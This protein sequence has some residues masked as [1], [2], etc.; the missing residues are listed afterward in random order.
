M[1]TIRGDLAA[2][3]GL[4][5]VAA[6]GSIV[7][8]SPAGIEVFTCHSPRDGTSVSLR[9]HPADPITGRP[10]QF[11][12]ERRSAGGPVT[13]FLLR[14]DAATSVAAE[15]VYTSVEAN[16]RGTLRLR[17]VSGGYLLSADLR[18]TLGVDSFV[19]GG[20]IALG[21]DELCTAKPAR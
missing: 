15:T 12:I 7:S 19:T 9:H 18:A 14:R 1:K 10:E 6:M 16:S 5:A 17:R 2:L 11:E 8:A 20:W 13:S 21:D 4:A 3:G